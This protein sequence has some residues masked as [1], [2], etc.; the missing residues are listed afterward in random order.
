MSPL[1]FFVGID[2]P[3]IY[4]YLLVGFNSLKDES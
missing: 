3:G 4:S 1:T 2:V